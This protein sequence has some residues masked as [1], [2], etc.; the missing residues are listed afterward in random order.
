M[1]DLFKSSHYIIS[2]SRCEN[3]P[4][5][6]RGHGVDALSIQLHVGRDMN[7]EGPEVHGGMGGIAML[8]HRRGQAADA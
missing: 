4:L 6:V 2:F 1:C 3:P 8:L 5:E 7:V